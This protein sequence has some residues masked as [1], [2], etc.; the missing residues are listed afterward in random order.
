MSTKGQSN[1]YGNTRGSRGKGKP[2]NEINFQYARDYNKHKLKIDFDKHKN[3]FGVSSEKDYVT[4]AIRFA[5]AVDRKNCV[6]FVDKYGSTHKYNT[7]TNTYVGVD[8]RG[9]IFTYFKPSTGEK[10]YHK[11]L[12]EKNK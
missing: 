12:E 2:T 1:Q 3:D 7:R 8:K 5:N 4:N 10:Y 11:K 6:S 9:Y